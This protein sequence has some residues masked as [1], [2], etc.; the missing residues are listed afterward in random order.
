MFS[1]LYIE[2]SVI[3]HPRT[4]AICQRFPQ[5]QQIPCKHYGEVFNK[6]SQNF[7]LQKKK[8]ALI[9]AKKMGKL[10][11]PTPVGY[12]IGGTKNYYFSHMLNC[13]FDCRY[14]FLQGMFRSA[15]Y[16]HFVNTEDFFDEIQKTIEEH[17]GET[18]TFFSGY[19]CDSLAL[20]P[21]TGFIESSLPFFAQN[22]K[23]LL[24]LRT[25]STQIQF[26]LKHPPIENCIVAYSLTPKEVGQ[27][28]EHK[29]P[30]LHQ[31]L[32]A[33]EKLSRKGWRIGLRLDPM[34]PCQNI[35][36]IYEPF[37]EQIF[38]KVDPKSI[39]S[40]SLGG[41]RLPKSAYQRIQKLYPDEKLFSYL[42]ESKSCMM[43]FPQS[44]EKALL[45]FCEKNILQNISKERF[46]PC[47]SSSPG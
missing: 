2:E 5:V 1:S 31:R 14:C 34:I 40:V 36:Q 19:D 43:S 37:F 42:Q 29:T 28:L 13:I 22:P 38:Q 41:L 12:G 33:I 6:H 9:L 44:A 47:Y 11:L 15:H 21:V 45:E 16:V 17:P 25:K 32:Q 39:H 30:P 20:E 4:Q 26:L 8:P 3:D 24:E 27:A 10:V 23:G 46:F 7:R 35:E 18:S